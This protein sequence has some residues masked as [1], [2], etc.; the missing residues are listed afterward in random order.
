MPAM[1]LNG[2]SEASNIAYIAVLY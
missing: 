1:P 2:F